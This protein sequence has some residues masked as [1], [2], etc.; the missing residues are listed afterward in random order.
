MEAAAAAATDLNQVLAGEGGC[1]LNSSELQQPTM[2]AVMKKFQGRRVARPMMKKMIHTA[3]Y[4]ERQKTLVRQS[5]LQ[6]EAFIV[7]R[8][9]S[10]LS[11]G[12]L[13]AVMVLSGW[14]SVGGIGEALVLE[15]TDDS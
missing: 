4:L 3:W 13:A 2:V 8:N 5:Q 12:A 10:H 9:V 11:R 1:T 7:Q 15:N 14:S 6:R